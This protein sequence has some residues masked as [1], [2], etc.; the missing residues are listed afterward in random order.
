M[1]WQDAI[2]LAPVALELLDQTCGRT[3]TPST[4][5]V[6]R[7]RGGP[8][9]AAIAWPPAD[10]RLDGDLRAARAL[11]QGAGF[12]RWTEPA[13]VERPVLRL[14]RAL[15][16][17]ADRRDCARRIGASRAKHGTLGAAAI[18]SWRCPVRECGGGDLWAGEAFG[19]RRFVSCFPVF[20]LALAAAIDWWGP[21][22]RRLSVPAGV[23][24]VHTGLLLVQYQVFMHGL[25][26]I[27]PYPRGA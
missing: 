4:C 8:A 6:A 5:R 21:T 26:D 24:V 16:L 15:H 17:D 19:S 18:C 27:A 13:L 25:R 20:A 10:D 3:I 9:G 11:P 12:M 14:A 1:R 22:L 23:V 7:D 2:L